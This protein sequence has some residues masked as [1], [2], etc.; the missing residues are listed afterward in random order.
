[1]LADIVSGMSLEKRVMIGLDIRCLGA[2]WVAQ[3]SNKPNK[4][5]KPNPAPCWFVISLRCR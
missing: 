4:P 1:M 5:N 2:R 3:F